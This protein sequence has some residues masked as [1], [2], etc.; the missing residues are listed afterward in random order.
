MDNDGD[1]LAG[2]HWH[3][4]M[5]TATSNSLSVSPLF[6]LKA[7]PQV[8]GIG[9]EC[10]STAATDRKVPLHLRYAQKLKSTSNMKYILTSFLRL[11]CQLVLPYLPAAKSLR[12][13]RD[14]G[15]ARKAC[16]SKSIL[17]TDRIIKDNTLN[18]PV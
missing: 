18:K 4:D 12:L 14:D 15:S 3:E 13:M 1:Q 8:S 16:T 7:D 2:A 11:C 6:D 17:S 10:N 9:E 5:S